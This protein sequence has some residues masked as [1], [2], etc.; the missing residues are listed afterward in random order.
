MDHFVGTILFA[1]LLHDVP[2][3]T[4]ALMQRTTLTRLVALHVPRTAHL[5]L[6]GAYKS[7]MHTGSQRI[8]IGT[9]VRTLQLL[10]AGMCTGSRRA[11]LGP[12]TF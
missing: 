2:S 10:R 6:R 9:R 1:V 7:L 4:L 12:L 8:P 5:K 11:S 3:N